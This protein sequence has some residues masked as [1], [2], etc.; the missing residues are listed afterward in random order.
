MLLNR[1]F[2]S[3]LKDVFGK[4]PGGLPLWGLTVLAPPPPRPA[5]GLSGPGGLLHRLHRRR[6]LPAPGSFPILEGSPFQVLS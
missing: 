1:E 4:S 3:R 6:L 5:L 2:R